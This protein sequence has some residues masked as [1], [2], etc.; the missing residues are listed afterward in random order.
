MDDFRSQNRGLLRDDP[1]AFVR[2][3]VF[4]DIAA[5]EH[6]SGP[7]VDILR[8]DQNGANWIEKKPSCP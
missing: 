1:V 7:P 3:M 6:R 4:S 2:S 8:V 5:N